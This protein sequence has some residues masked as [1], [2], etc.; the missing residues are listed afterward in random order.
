MYLSISQALQ[1]AIAGIPMFGVDTCGFAGNTDYELCS[2]WQ[3]LS[4]F[5]PFYRYIHRSQVCLVEFFD[6]YQHLSRLYPN[7]IHVCSRPYPRR[8]ELEILE[9]MLISN[10]HLGITTSL[11]KRRTYGQALPKRHGL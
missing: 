6:E 7:L 2:R 1:F 10:I 8:P 4:A 11:H 3:Q 5:F 9:D